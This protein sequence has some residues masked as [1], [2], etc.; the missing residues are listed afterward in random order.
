MVALDKLGVAW[1]EKM[2]F[3]RSLPH[4]S[5]DKNEAAYAAYL[6]FCESP[7]RRNSPWM[8][9]AETPNSSSLRAHAGCLKSFS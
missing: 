8:N 2:R 7:L 5:Q 1:A 6:S 9:S 3:A 4:H